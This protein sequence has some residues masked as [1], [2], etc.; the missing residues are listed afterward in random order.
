MLVSL[1]LM[2]YSWSYFAL[3]S[4]GEPTVTSLPCTKMAKI[5]QRFSASC[6]QWVERMKAVLNWSENALMTFQSWS[7]A[8]GSSPVL[9]SSRKH[10]LGYATSAM[11]T[12]SLRLLPPLRFF[13]NFF[14]Y[15]SNNRFCISQFVWTIISLWF[16]PLTRHTKWRCSSTVN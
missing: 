7:L 12:Q 9:G 2:V 3:R 15:S 8:I 14:A 10:S 4:S 13:A 5:W 11:A 16:I 1:T 6:I